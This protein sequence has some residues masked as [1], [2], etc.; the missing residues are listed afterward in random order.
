MFPG[1]FGAYLCSL[2]LCRWYETRCGVLSKSYAGSISIIPGEPRYCMVTAKTDAAQASRA[3]CTQQICAA[4]RR[5]PCKSSRY[6]HCF[7]ELMETQ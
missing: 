6:L 7:E 4:L 3:G 1:L 2:R 5:V